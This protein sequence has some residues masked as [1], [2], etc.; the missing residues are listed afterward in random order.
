MGLPC[1]HE[2]QARWYDRAGGNVLKL[3]D[4][5]PHWHFEKPPQARLMMSQ[6]ERDQNDHTLGDNTL[7]E[8]TIISGTPPPALSLP[9]EDPDLPDDLLRI[10]EPAIV[11]RKGRPPGALNKAWAP[12][13][14]RLTPAQKRLQQ[15]YENST[16]RDPSAFELAPDLPFSQVPDSQPSQR[17]RGGRGRGRGHGERGGRGGRGGRGRGSNKQSNWRYSWLVHDEL[18]AVN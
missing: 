8:A 5:H 3:E 16:R 14:M 11:K 7:N 4:I 13:A 12:P 6:E 18:S 10:N 2:I 17:G 15:A 9:A 1:A